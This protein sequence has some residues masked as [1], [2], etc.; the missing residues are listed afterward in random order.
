MM[1]TL[2]TD[3]LSI[4]VY[5][6]ADLHDTVSHRGIL[7]DAGTSSAAPQQRRGCFSC[8]RLAHMY[9]NC[10]HAARP[11]MHFQNHPPPFLPVHVDGIGELTDLVDTGAQRTALLQRHAP[12]P[13]S[14]W[15]SSP[16]QGKGSAI[17]VGA[18]DLCIRTEAGSKVLVDVPVFADLPAGLNLVAD[19]LMSGDMALSIQNGEVQ[20]R[21][22]RIALSPSVDE[23]PKGEASGPQ[24]E[25]ALLHQH[26]AIFA[27]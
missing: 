22:C 23:H 20:L 10:P 11:C 4:F 5:R 6:A 12:V 2:D 14:Q 18:V 1:S 7:A 27:D 8:G 3:S 16:L 25:S 26:S 17:P 9:K 15:T 21:S 24:T 13:L 19:H